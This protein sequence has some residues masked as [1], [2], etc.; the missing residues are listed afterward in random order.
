MDVSLVD[1]EDGALGLV[2]KGEED[3]FAAGEGAGGIVGI[4][5]I[6][7][8]CF[9]IGGD[10]AFDV[11]GV[12]LGE[13]DLGDMRSTAH[14]AALC[15]FEGGIGNN[16]ATGRRGEGEDGVVEGLGRAGIDGEVIF[17]NAELLGECSG[18]FGG[19]TVDVVATALGGD[20]GDGFTGGLTGPEGILVGVDEDGA[21]RHGG[22]HAAG[23]GPGLG[24][25]GLGSTV[26]SGLLG[27][28]GE[29]GFGEDG[30]GGGG[31]GGHAHEGAA[32]GG[33]GGKCG[34]HGV[35]LRIRGRVIDSIRCAEVKT[36][37]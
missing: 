28:S 16:E 8:A 14:G 5:D 34:V 27:R 9:R 11:M 30:H 1:E 3:V 4:T 20:G 26:C 18:E 33:G 31:D 25:S 10:E 21:G 36:A 23:G 17:G 37:P 29:M 6:D 32:G 22:A 2:L 35:L 7:E 24:G 13:G 19:L 12:A 15:G